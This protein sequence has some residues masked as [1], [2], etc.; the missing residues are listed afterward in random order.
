M[1]NLVFSIA[2]LLAVSSSYSQK[3]N[4]SGSWKINEELSEMGDQ[5][6][7]A[8]N[9][10]VLKHSRKTL[11]FEKNSS[12]QGQ[13]YTTNDVFTLDGKECE[14]PG[15]MDSIKKSTALFDKKTKTLKITSII[16]MDDGSDAEIIE[17]LVM[18][19]E[20]LVIEST[21]SSIYGELIERFVFD[22]Q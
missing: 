7:L 15:W 1:R 14:N 18:D 8:P 11:E 16:P 2:L 6:S 20:Q 12:F 5:F 3:V 22:K 17:E 4:F 21:A 9:S 10:I 19:G 13:D